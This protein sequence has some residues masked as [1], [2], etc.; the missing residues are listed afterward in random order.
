MNVFKK[1]LF[2]NLIFSYLD[3]N[4]KL[5]TFPSGYIH[6]FSWGIR[7]W[8]QNFEIPGV[9]VE[10]IGPKSFKNYVLNPFMGFL[11]FS[12]YSHEPR[13]GTDTIGPGETVLLPDEG[14]SRKLRENTEILKFQNFWKFLEISYFVLFFKGGDFFSVYRTSSV[15]YF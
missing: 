1:H 12:S 9:R 5:Q 15:Y 2:G 8:G 6:S 7:I 13:V 14:N 11:C 10:K 4:L 3:E